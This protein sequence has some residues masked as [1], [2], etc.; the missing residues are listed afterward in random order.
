MGIFKDK[1][2]QFEGVTNTS[3]QKISSLKTHER[4]VPLEEGIQV[5]LSLGQTLER[6]LATTQDSL[7]DVEKKREDDNEKEENDEKQEIIDPRIASKQS[8]PLLSLPGVRKS[9]VG[10]EESSGASFDYFI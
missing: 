10:T 3:L 6:D 5:N 7:E 1:V 8:S 2:P 9:P 4:L